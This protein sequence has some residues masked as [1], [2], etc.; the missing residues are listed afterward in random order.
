VKRVR[1]G[2]EILTKT[3]EVFAKV[4]LSSKKVQELVGE[5]AAASQ[6]QAQGIEQ[7]NRA[8]SEMDKVVQK[9]AASAEESA[10]AAEEM[11]AQ[12][13]TMKRFVFELMALMNGQNGNS[14]GPIGLRAVTLSEASSASQEQR[15]GNGKGYARLLE[16]KMKG[17]IKR[18]EKKIPFPKRDKLKPEQIIPMEGDFKEF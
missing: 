8:I 1:H 7:I 6:E 9:N 11:N 17:G 15:S 5:I 14:Q 3:N 2:S 4:A 16:N 13:E 10:A 18:E 12:A